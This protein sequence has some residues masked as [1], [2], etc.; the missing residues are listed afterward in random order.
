MQSADIPVL[1]EY[2]DNPF[3]AK[4]PPLLLQREMLMALANHP[5]FNEKERTYPAQLR[6]HCIMRL[7]R[8]FEPLERQLQLAERFGMLLRQ[9]YVGRNPLTHDYIR[10][11]QNGA[12]RI[13]ANSLHVATLHPVENTAASFALVGCSGIGK[14]K[15]IEKVLLQYPQRIQH[16]APFT[17]VQIVWLKLDCPHQGSPKQL[18]INFFSA[19]DRLVGTNYFNA[20]GSRRASVDEMMVHMA[21]VANLHALG[22]LVIDEIQHLNKTKIGPDALLNFLVT[23]VNTISVPVI[24]IGTLSAVPMLQENFRQARRASGLGSL[25]WDRMQKNKAWD[26]FIEKLWKHQWTRDHTPISQEVRDVLYDE[27]QGI[28]D[29]VVKLFMLAQL[30][31]V[32][33]GDVRGTQEILTPQLLRKVARED[34]RIV[35]P[36]IDALRMN[37]SNALLKYDDLLP[38]QAH[39][40]QI[41]ADAIQSQ[42]ADVLQHSTKAN[43]VQTPTQNSE[44]LDPILVALRSL[45]VADDVAKVLL[46]EARA[47]HSSADPLLL[48]A[49]IAEKLAAKPI[50]IKKPKS[51]KKDELP[52]Q[53][54]HDLRR[55][56]TQGKQAGHSG[57]EALLVAGMVKP[58]L[59]DI[60]A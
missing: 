10:H 29:I 6:K 35:R 40:E 4:L 56:V 36:M 55:I 48:M 41:I 50:K 18:C 12:E 27:S 31:V 44:D 9:G 32:G 42:G 3:I 7:G 22:V 24:L 20:Y 52:A 14:S 8:Y 54:E 1:R 26:Y 45:N 25:V 38:L 53:P 49:A 37:D 59:L 57:Y 34:F 58:P 39:V 5:E 15:S 30:R 33:I 11:L 23:L 17:L 19:V 60:A 51:P 16:S 21:H 47:Q 43:K 28:L 2:Q 46:N 13:E